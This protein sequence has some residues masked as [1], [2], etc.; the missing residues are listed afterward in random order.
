MNK[1]LFCSIALTLLA[2]AAVWGQTPLP[3]ESPAQISFVHAVSAAAGEM[4]PTS[5]KLPTVAKPGEHPCI[6]FTPAELANFKNDLQSTDAGK[7][8]YATLIGLANGAVSASIN[9]PDP[10]GPLSQLHNRWD[11]PAQAHNGLAY[12]AGN[13]G[14]AYALTGDVKYAKRAAEILTGYA[15]RYALY[16]DH[17]GAN[18]ND[19]GKV[20]AQRL[21][22]AMW[23]I[24]LIQSYDYIHD[25]GVLTDQNKQDIENK[26][27]KTC[28]VFIRLKDPAKEVAERDA[29]SPGWR[30]E[31]PPTK[32]GAANWLFFYNAATL[33]GGAVMGDKNMVDLGA[34]DIRFL[35]HNGVGSDG[36]WLEGAIGYQFFAMNALTYSLETAAHQGI[37]L[38]SFDDF[39][40][41]KLF[42]SALRYA[43]PDDSAPGIGDSSRVKYGGSDTLSYD[44]AWLR[45]SDPAYVNMIDLTPRRLQFS[46]GIYAP[47]RVF[48]QLPAV[49]ATKLSSTVFES[50]GQAIMRDDRV[51]ALLNYGPVGPVHSHFDKLNLILY[52][53]GDNG[54]GDEIGGEPRAHSYEDPLHGQWTKVSL[55]HNTMTM[56]Q[57]SQA[58]AKGT[59]PVF[60]STGPVKIMRATCSAAY[61][62]SVLD[63]TVVV[64]PDSVIDLYQ[65]SSSASHTWDRTLRYQGL[66]N[67][68]ASSKLPTP[69]E[70][71]AAAPSAPFPG[72]PFGTSDGYQHFHVVASTGADQGWNGTWKTTVGDFTAT[73]AGSP[74]QKVFTGVGPDWDQIAVARQTGTTAAF[75]ATYQMGA[76]GNPVQ[77]VA[78]LPAGDGVR[79]CEVTQKDGAKTLIV[80][81]S[82][83]PWE[84]AGWKSDAQVFYAR[85][86]GTQETVMLCG[87]T[88]AVGAGGT[89]HLAAAGNALAQGASGSLA[90]VSQWS[91]PQVPAG[92]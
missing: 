41:K 68:L 83:S 17:K 37:D 69:A 38:W 57:H 91:P 1:L 87:G 86:N 49:Q 8:A 44:Y 14:L 79:A 45:Y 66:L 78:W 81:S 12:M 51:Y 74:E 73:V 65:A 16:P 88:S 50:L 23:L 82:G 15:D 75:A 56:D 9:F 26:L 80:T 34:A 64:T 59:L 60:E 4:T 30:T 71:G 5:V 53:A 28:V 25:S 22:E 72:T 48:Q 42:D 43:Y 3:E 67:V 2:G 27:I 84:V 11:A 6:Y 61:P 92:K 19:T 29:K 36:M 76:W 18:A 58:L 35:I 33:M 7:Q 32:K 47:T 63:R 24:P 85:Q 90:I 46:E 31:E 55:A 77:T 13:C 40:A 21:S 89:V 70:H 10:K 39:R 62:G 54:A 20:M 52:C